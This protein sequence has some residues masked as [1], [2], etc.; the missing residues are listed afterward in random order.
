MAACKWQYSLTWPFGSALP[1][2]TYPM[3]AP[4]IA[5]ELKFAGRSSLQ[6]VHWI[7]CGRSSLSKI[8]TFGSP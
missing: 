6:K 2:L 8:A 5:R 3:Y 4:L 1:V 7:F